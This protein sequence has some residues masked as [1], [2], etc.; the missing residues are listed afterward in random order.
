[1]MNRKHHIIAY[2]IDDLGLGGAQKLLSIIVSALPEQYSPVILC[3]SEKDQP[4][5]ETFRR[6]NI[7]VFTFRRNSH[8]DLPRLMA[9]KRTL[10]AQRVDLIHSYLH[11]SN[12]YAYLAGRMLARPVI[13]SLQ[14]NKPRIGRFQN[15][16]LSWAFRRADRVMV[17]SNAG[18]EYLLNTVRVPLD[19]IALIKNCFPSEMLPTPPSDRTTNTK[20]IGYTGRL[21]NTVKRI[22]LIL[23]ALP[24]LFS[25]EP[26]A[27]CVL[28]GAG[29][30]EQMLRSLTQKLGIADRV[31]FK[32]AVPDVFEVMREYSCLVL[33]S[34]F[35]GLPMVIIEALSLGIPVIATGVGDVKDLVLD[36]ITGRIIR[37]ESPEG[38]ARLMREVLNDPALAAKTRERGPALVRETFSAEAFRVN[39]TALYESLL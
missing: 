20:T 30:D 34:A 29:P 38:L 37:D 28:V 6:A 8:L 18:R 2:L 17:N 33:P 24:L 7:P 13:L 3:I 4:Y 11:A 5:G 19:K 36:N 25:E 16:A 1:M 15:Y 14:S 12:V 31:E 10:A 32:G 39:L 9:I 23:R 35:E 27:K 21:D 26:D 22:D